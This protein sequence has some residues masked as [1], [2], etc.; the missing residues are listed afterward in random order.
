MSMR[1]S[2]IEFDPCFDQHTCRLVLKVVFEQQ[3]QQPFVSIAFDRKK[4]SR[5]GVYVHDLADE[6]TT[7]LPGRAVS[8]VYEENMP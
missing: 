1:Y 2:R 7:Y 3:R 5:Y 4:L 8:T 6:L